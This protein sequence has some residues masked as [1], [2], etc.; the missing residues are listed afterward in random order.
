MIPVIKRTPLDNAAKIY[1]CTSTASFS[2]QYRIGAVLK[3][4]VNEKVLSKAVVDLAERFPLLYSQVTH[5]KY[6]DYLK[7]ATDFDIVYRDKGKICSPFYLGRTDRPLFRVLFNDKAISVEIFHSLTD[8]IGGMTYLKSLLAHYYS[9]LGEKISPCNGIL[10]VDEKSKPGELVDAYQDI[11]QVG[12]RMKR[13]DKDAFQYSVE[14]EKNFFGVTNLS[15]SAKSVNQLAKSHGGTVTQLLSAVLFTA[16]VQQKNRQKNNTTSKKPIII[17]VPINVRSIIKSETLRNF[18]LTVNLKIDEKQDNTIQQKVGSI[19]KQI[20]KATEESSVRRMISQNV[21]EEKQWIAKVSPMKWKRPIMGAIVNFYG[22]RKYTTQLSNLG[23]HKIPEE[24]GKHIE[25][26]YFFLGQAS[27]NAFLLGAVAVNDTIT[28]S[29]SSKSKD[30]S[31]Q[32]YFQNFLEQN[33]ISVKVRKLE[34]KE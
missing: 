17:C 8:G 6:W 12:L 26:F 33:N 34:N 3:E 2:P 27:I 5:G 13:K 7:P 29:F 18:A 4:K 1:V 25:S 28:L 16:L 32:K 20:E 30:D 24:L 22:E 14:K 19:A 21:H 15:F 11:Y 31:V 10:S 9:L 23:Y